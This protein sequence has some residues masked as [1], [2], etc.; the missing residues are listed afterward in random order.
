MRLATDDD[1][2]RAKLTYIGPP[3]YTFPVHLPYTQYA[4]FAV[5]VPIFMTIH[6]LLT[7]SPPDLFPA[8]E[9]AFA[10]VATSVVF[11]HVNADYPARK[12]IRTALTDWRRSK[13][14][15]R[16]IRDPAYRASHIKIR[17][18]IR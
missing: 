10:M 17:K 15:D 16:D 8:Y 4:L 11:K 9:I 13:T 5:L 2:Y 6:S 18:D 7:W 14:C 1:I 12:V 3:G